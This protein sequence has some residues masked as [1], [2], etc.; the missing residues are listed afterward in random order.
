MD[1]EQEKAFKEAFASLF[2]E[3]REA[4]AEF[5]VEWINPNHLAGD[6]IGR[7]LNTRAMKL[8][9]YLVKKVRK[10]IEVRV[11]VPGAVHLASEITI[12]DRIN[13][14]LSGADIRVHANEYNSMFM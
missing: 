10:G 8:G 11:L 9:D 4:V 14:M 12:S 7:I 6:L 3:D 13:Y 5:L 1:K 2:K